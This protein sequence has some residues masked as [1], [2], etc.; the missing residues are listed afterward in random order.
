MECVSAA[1]VCAVGVCS[2]GA[3]CS[4][5]EVASLPFAV[6]EE[7]AGEEATV[8]LDSNELAAPSTVE[9][10]GVG[11]FAVPF[12][13]TVACALT[14]VCDAVMMAAFVATESLDVV[15][16]SEAESS[17]SGLLVLETVDLSSGCLCLLSL[18]V[19]DVE[20]DAV[21]LLPLGLFADLLLEDL[22]PFDPVAA[23]LLTSV[24]SS[25]SVD[26]LRLSH[27]LLELFV[28]SFQF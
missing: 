2:T 13:T 24:V 14:A 15:V 20:V 25:V 28:V 19:F 9:V 3:V 4:R 1:M 6:A 5:A 7:A 10:V 18:T 16:L 8:G 27:H 22:M 11:L 17:S 23:G 12:L 26:E 21:D